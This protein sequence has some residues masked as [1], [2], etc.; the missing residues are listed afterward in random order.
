M[1]DLLIPL[2]SPNPAAW[3]RFWAKVVKAE[4]GCW[5]WT[6][7]LSDRGYPYFQI[8]AKRRRA[9]R[10]LWEQV[11]APIPDGYELDH[12][13]RNRA[14]VNPDHLEV[15]THSENVL[16]GYLVPG[17]KRGGPKRPDVA[18]CRHGDP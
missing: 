7:R 8:D 18:T 9:H 17:R 1:T 3:K 16:R 6:G 15:V 14:C 4:S 5:F 2:A 11:N 10:W 12:L 13:C